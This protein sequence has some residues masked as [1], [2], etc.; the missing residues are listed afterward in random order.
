MIA[1]SRRCCVPEAAEEKSLRFVNGCNNSGRPATQVGTTGSRCCS[2]ALPAH[3][4]P[5]EARKPRRI[6][7][8][9]Y[10]DVERGRSVRTSD[11]FVAAIACNMTRALSRAKSERPEQKT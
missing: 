10:T 6:P 8:D 1:K 9:I 5:H 4:V 7:R 3:R 11:G 2:P